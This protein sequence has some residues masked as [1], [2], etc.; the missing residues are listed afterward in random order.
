MRFKRTYLLF[1]ILLLNSALT[2]QVRDPVYIVNG[3]VQYGYNS[4]KNKLPFHE[5][6]SLVTFFLRNNQKAKSVFLGANFGGWS[7]RA[8][9]MMRTDSGWITQ[10]KLGTGK[11]WY[12]FIIDGDWRLDQDNLIVEKDNSGQRHSVYYKTNSLFTLRLKGTEKKVYLTGSFNNWKADE[13]AMTK[14]RNGWRLPLYLRPGTH[15][16]SLLL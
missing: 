8:L 14:T 3:V 1:F 7:P 11:Y 2:G 16:Y 6:D 13:L 10:V 9:P 15:F 4:F 12:Q 5:K